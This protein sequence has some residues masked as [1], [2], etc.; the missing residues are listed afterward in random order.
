MGRTNCRNEYTYNDPRRQRQVARA[1]YLEALEMRMLFNAVWKSTVPAGNWST[2][3]NWVGGSGPGGVPAA[4]DTVEF[5]SSAT[6][7]VDVAGAIVVNSIVINAQAGADSNVTFSF[8]QATPSHRRRSSLRPNRSK[9]HHRK[10]AKH[11]G[12]RCAND[13][14]Q[15]SGFN[16]NAA[17]DADHGRDKR[18]AETCRCIWCAGI[19]VLDSAA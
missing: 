10:I 8:N 6:V 18:A 3:T 14:T 9:H 12:G 4:G 17:A 16:H 7:T 5:D 13:P 1:L 2:G 15:V 11:F 19:S